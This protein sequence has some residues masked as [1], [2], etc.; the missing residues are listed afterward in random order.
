MSESAGTY[1]VNR[2]GRITGSA[3]KRRACCLPYSHH[4]YRPPDADEIAA[5]MHY[6]EWTQEQFALCISR[7]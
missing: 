6:A 7:E 3:L 2:Q 1:T 5:L 4:R